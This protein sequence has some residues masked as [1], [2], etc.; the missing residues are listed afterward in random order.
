MKYTTKQLNEQCQ[1]I[2]DT[3]LVPI[4]IDRGKRYGDINGD[5]LRNVAMHGW[6]KAA[7]G[8]EECMWRLSNHLDN[9]IQRHECPDKDDLENACLDGLN[10]MFYTLILLRRE[11]S[12]ETM[13]ELLKND[14]QPQRTDGNIPA[15]GEQK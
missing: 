15:F 7:M 1:K 10:Y 14:K 2:M 12:D 4:R 8:A 5:C 6:T 3:E 9:L 11:Q 13:L